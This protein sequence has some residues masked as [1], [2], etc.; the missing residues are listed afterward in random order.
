VSSPLTTVYWYHLLYTEL[1]RSKGIPVD[2]VVADTNKDDKVSASN[3][4]DVHVTR[5]NEKMSYQDGLE[6]PLGHR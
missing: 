2:E 5:L 4:V 1:N 6:L 3:S